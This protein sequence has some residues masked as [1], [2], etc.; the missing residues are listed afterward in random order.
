MSIRFRSGIGVEPDHAEQIIQAA[1]RV[2]SGAR[3][4]NLVDARELT[5]MSSEARQVFARQDATNVS[6]IAVL[7]R[8]SLQRTMGNVYLSVARPRLRTRLFSDES[9]ATAW[10]QEQNRRG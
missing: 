2:A 10:L 5:Y 3:H 9:E 7:V 4:G 1:K 8:S 6:G